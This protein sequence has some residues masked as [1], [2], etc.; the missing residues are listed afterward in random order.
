MPYKDADKERDRQAKKSRKASEKVADIG[1]IPAVVNPERRER[2]RNDLLYFLQTYFPE[3]TGRSPF[4][5]DHVEVI[6]RIEEV[7]TG[8]GKFANV[9]FRGFAKTTISENA[10]IWATAYGHLR[11][12]P[13][14]GAT[15]QKSKENI[16]S[17]KSE[18]S[19]ND[20][21]YEDFPEI[22][23]AIRAL[24]GKTQRCKSQTHQ[25]EQTHISWVSDSVVFPTIK[26]TAKDAAEKGIPVDAR[27][28]TLAS[29]A[30]ILTRGITGSLRGLTHKRQ[31]GTQQRPDGVLIDDPQT[32]Q[33]AD[34]AH[35]VDKRLRIIKASI[36]KLAGHRNSIAVICNG[37]VIQPNDA[38]DQ[39]LDHTRNP[40]WEGKR[41]PMVQKWADAHESFWMG[42]YKRLRTTYDPERVGD[43]ERARRESTELYRS[44]QAEADAGAVVCWESCFDPENEVSAI[45]HAYNFLIDDGEEVF[46]SEAQGRPLVKDASAGTVVVPA[47]QIRSKFNGIPRGVVPIWATHV[48]AF[49]D[50]HQ[51]LIYWVKI[52]W[53]EGFTGA[54]IDYGTW[55]EQPRNYFAMRTAKPNITSEIEAGGVEAKITAA[56]TL[57]TDAILGTPC[58]QEG[59]DGLSEI[60]VA[61]AMVDAGK[62]TDE[63]YEFARR[64]DH[65][66]ILS[67]SHGTGIGAKNI[68]M[69]KYQKKPGEI[70]HSN[71]VIASAGKRAIH[72]VTIDTN[73]WKTFVHNRLRTPIGDPGSLSLFGRSAE[74]HKLFAD[75]LTSET[76]QQTSGRGRSLDEWAIKPAKPDNHWFDCVVGATVAASI[77]GISLRDKPQPRKRQKPR[78]KV[79]DI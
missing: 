37:T 52:A 58:E 41:I 46:A 31:D 8:G 13:V 20:L 70:L 19:S 27:G 24:E 36:V 49:F 60:V 14:I 2:G 67:P 43:A 1:E 6:Q 61:R 75:H 59:D 5:A 51:E 64:S 68:P 32:E 28:Y 53:G 7:L 48:T 33:S 47:A 45:Q 63:I 18:L 66:A 42:E 44:R 78:K 50:V 54:V 74:T 55:P 57:C 12:I 11:F 25:G 10:S 35:Q 69:S 29:G 76:A 34:T 4:S 26:L 9:V 23:H 21:L 40:S 72:H 65:K 22:C 71:Y 77:C 38:M 30:K 73:F 79:W 17:I 3:S 16:D 39:L 56:L 62:W 15:S